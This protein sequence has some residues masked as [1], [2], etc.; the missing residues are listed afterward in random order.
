MTRSEAATIAEEYL[1]Y[2]YSLGWGIRRIA[3]A[4][5]IR[6]PKSRSAWTEGYLIAR[7]AAWLLK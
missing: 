7:L 3:K 6:L 1:L 5:N 2:R 4:S